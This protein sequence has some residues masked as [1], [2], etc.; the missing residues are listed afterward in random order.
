MIIKQNIP[1]GYYY[2]LIDGINTN[3][4]AGDGYWGNSN[5]TIIND[6]ISGLT[7]QQLFS[8]FDNTVTSPTIFTTR[9]I[10]SGYINGTNTTTDVNNLFN[11]Y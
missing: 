8:L 3:E 7:N 11:S 6:N 2:D 9:L 5:T 1:I 4:V 10:N